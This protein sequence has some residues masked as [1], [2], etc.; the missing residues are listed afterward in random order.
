[1]E[2]NGVLK[3]VLNDFLSAY[4]QRD[5]NVAF[6]DWLVD[7]LRKKLPD[8]TAEAGRVLVD[9]IAGAVNGFNQKLREVDAAPAS[10]LS[11]E[12]WL[13]EQLVKSSSALPP[14]E[15]GKQLL[16]MEDELI[17]SNTAALSMDGAQDTKIPDAVAD[18]AGWN[19]DT[20]K[21]KAREIAE[22]AVL[23]GLGVA[24]NAAKHKMDG[25]GSL[26]L[27][28]A[29][30]E[31]LQDGLTNALE[32]VKMLVAGA[33]RV[34]A[35]NGAVAGLDKDTP[36][37]VFVSIAGFVV[38]GGQAIFAAVNGKIRPEEAAE[39]VCKAGI[40][41]CAYSVDVLKWHI[42]GQFPVIGTVAVELLGGL[43]DHMK[44]PEFVDNVY[45]VFH[46]MAV[47]TLDGMRQPTGRQHPLPQE[48]K[49]AKDKQT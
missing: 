16:E 27:R 24:A 33:I 9:G 32:E 21:K 47:A 7:M 48:I 14:E 38:E 36:I 44:S 28:E 39:K 37:E 8:L 41:A 2:T 11:K 31:A 23:A 10:G 20:L 15:A 42:Q 17:Q 6:Q 3:N 25:D 30:G 19:K 45:T 13:A 49:T 5:Q 35:E 1:M 40:T 46:D 34:A 43:F 29:V 12:E 22:Q 18:P 4:A 26:R